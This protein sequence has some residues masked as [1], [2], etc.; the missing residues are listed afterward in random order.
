MAEILIVLRSYG[1]STEQPGFFGVCNLR[2]SYA[3]SVA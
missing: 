2:H 1:E 3:K